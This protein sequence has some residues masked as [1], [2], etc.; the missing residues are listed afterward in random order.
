MEWFLT[1]NSTL[2]RILRTLVQGLL[3]V[4]IAELPELVGL[5]DINDTLQAVIVAVAMAILSPIMSEI[6]KHVEEVMGAKRAA[7]AMMVMSQ[8]EE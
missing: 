1:S 2:A 5:L 3:G 7:Q 4:L 6:G 8:E